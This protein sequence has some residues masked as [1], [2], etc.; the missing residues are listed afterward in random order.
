[1]TQR[2]DGEAATR[3]IRN[4]I[5]VYA[6]IIGIAMVATG[7]IITPDVFAVFA[8]MIAVWLGRGR[9]FIR[10]WAP[11]IAI[12]L[13]WEAM[14]GLANHVGFP[15]HVA[16]LAG[17]GRILGFGEPLALRLQHA[18][19]V[20]GRIGPLDVILTI[21]YLM[22]FLVPLAVA[23]VFWLQNR[24]L[25]YRYAVTL[26]AM[27]FAQF[28]IA[29]VYPAAPPRFATEY[30][31]Q[32]PIVDISAVVGAAIGFHPASWAYEHLIGNP[33][34]AFPSL[35]AAYPVLAA[36]FLR[37]YSKRAALGMLLYACVVWFGIIYLGH[38]WAIDAIAGIFLAVV[39][40]V[41]V[42][43]VW[44]TRPLRLQRRDEEATSPVGA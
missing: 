42:A 39:C 1:M 16:E 5:P 29:I 9:R 12:L 10:D 38:H 33:V 22:H 41:V 6:A 37:T 21:V 34:A 40:Y 17:I 35:H 18:F 27:S 26:M 8:G 23:F 4:A 24:A 3:F 44:W 13:A 11:F 7:T 31:V 15:V 43:R 20:P 32:L 2:P 28:F 36:L 25:F 19:Y 30:G 14:R